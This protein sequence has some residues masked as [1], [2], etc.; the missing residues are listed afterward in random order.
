MRN[1][2]PGGVLVFK[3]FAS[4]RAK[5]SK[6]ARFIKLRKNIPTMENLTHSVARLGCMTIY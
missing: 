2:F 3:N 6:G 1:V 5:S 4:I